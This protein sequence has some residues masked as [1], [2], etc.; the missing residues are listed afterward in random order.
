MSPC[1]WDSTF[2]LA[3]AELHAW[4]DFPI[5]PFRRWLLRRVNEQQSFLWTFV[6]LDVRPIPWEEAGMLIMTSEV[7]HSFFFCFSFLLEK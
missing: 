2:S 4:G 6:F 3:S 7:E 5:F 1:I